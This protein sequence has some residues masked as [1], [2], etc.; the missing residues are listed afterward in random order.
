MPIFYLLHCISSSAED[1]GCEE[2]QR[3][4]R[5]FLIGMFLYVLTY[6]CLKN[7]VILGKLNSEVYDSI[8]VG[9]I[10]IF[11]AD[12]FIMG[13]VYKNYFGRSI[14]NEA[15][16][17]LLDGDKTKF[18]FDK[19]NHTYIK[20]KVEEKSNIDEIANIYPFMEAKPKLDNADKQIEPFEKVS[21]PKSEQ[22]N[23]KSKKRKS[24]KSNID[25]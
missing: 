11:C 9:V 25:Y 1:S 15:N 14:V 21:N 24:K 19:K 23:K 16:E 7:L 12:A 20:A 10:V 3:N 18:E 8:I 4:S 22:K 13:Y 17:V 2:G 5:I 6:V